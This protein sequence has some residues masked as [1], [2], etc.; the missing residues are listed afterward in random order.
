V[1]SNSLTADAQLINK[2]IKQRF[3]LSR[4]HS[5]AGIV[6]LGIFMVEHL[7]TNSTALL[8]S[9]KYNEQIHLIQSI[10]FLPLLEIFLVAI[11]LIFHAGYGI[12]L[13]MISK[14][15]TQTYKYERNRLFFFQ[16]VTGIT[17]LVFIIYHVWS[18][19]LAPVFYGTE[20]N[21]DLV[22]SHLEN[23]FVFSFYVIGVVGAVFHFSNGI[24]TGLIT[25]GVT[26]GP[27]SQR[28]AQRICLLFFAVFGVLGVTSLFAFI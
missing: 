18:F 11:P 21:F 24:R 15:N 14:S 20:I 17:T 9:E 25:W 23:V 12:Y 27:A 4:L 19:R 6:P 26:K 2:N 8:G 16:R 7:L 3:V 22:N 10:P 5:L 1:Q 13:S 28:I